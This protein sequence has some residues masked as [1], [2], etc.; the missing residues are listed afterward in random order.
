M[1]R[2]LIVA[3]C[4]SGTPVKGNL[5]A[6]LRRVLDH[7]PLSMAFLRAKVIQEADASGSPPIEE[8]IEK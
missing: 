6:S 8:I 3:R 4:R 2:E 5:L 1:Y 7:L